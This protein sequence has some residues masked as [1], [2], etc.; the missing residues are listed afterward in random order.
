MDIFIY[1]DY[2]ITLPE[3]LFDVII[4]SEQPFGMAYKNKKPV[5]AYQSIKE[6]KV[7]DRGKGKGVAT[8]L[9]TDHWIGSCG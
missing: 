3:I 8:T 1:T 7:A 4:Q 9:W 5:K 6:Q 2:D